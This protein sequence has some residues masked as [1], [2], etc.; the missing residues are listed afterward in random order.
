MPIILKSEKYI[1]Q[2]AGYAWIALNEIPGI[3]NTESTHIGLG[4]NSAHDQ[5]IITYNGQTKDETQQHIVSSDRDVV[6]WL[7]R[8]DVH[9]CIKPNGLIE[10]FRL[11]Y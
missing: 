3:T 9:I 4:V 5:N 8:Q 1:L 7:G 10:L 2:A 6:F 11:V